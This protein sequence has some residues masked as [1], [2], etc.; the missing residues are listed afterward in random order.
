MACTFK[1]CF[2]KKELLKLSFDLFY[3]LILL[4]LF[5]PSAA[6]GFMSVSHDVLAFG[7][8]PKV[9]LSALTVNQL[10]EVPISPTPSPP[11]T[12]SGRQGNSSG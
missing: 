8:Y 4:L 1:V 10:I 9:L 2:A 12:D 5:N 3:V 7:W 6:F 11:Q